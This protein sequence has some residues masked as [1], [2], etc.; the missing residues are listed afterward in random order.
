MVKYPIS[1]SIRAMTGTTVQGGIDMRCAGLIR[2]A[3]SECAI[4][5]GLTI[6]TRYLAAGMRKS[7]WHKTSGSMAYIA[8]I[9][10]WHVVVVLSGGGIT[11]VTVDTAAIDALVIES[12][13]GKGLGVVAH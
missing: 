10:G 9:I 13:T 3:D 8:I 1:E 4:M 11:V 12:G 5:T 7:P 2:L 6:N